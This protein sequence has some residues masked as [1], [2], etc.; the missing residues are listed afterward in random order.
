MLTILLCPFL[1]EG[2]QV[3]NR[4][5]NEDGQED[6]RDNNA[7]DGM[8]ADEITRATFYQRHKEIMKH[9]AKHH[10][11]SNKTNVPCLPEP[12]R[13]VHDQV[14]GQVEHSLRM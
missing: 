4:A 7:Y 10:S 6:I 1:E 14:I 3:E 9:Q 2:Q 5:R 12:A 8:H 11:D 13:H